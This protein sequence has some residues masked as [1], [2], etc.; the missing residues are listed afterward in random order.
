VLDA[1]HA[2]VDQSLVEADERGGESSYR[3]LA[4]VRQFG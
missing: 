4:V 3:L 2:L 1:L